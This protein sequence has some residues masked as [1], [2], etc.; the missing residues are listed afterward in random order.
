[1]WLIALS[2]FGFLS[3]AMVKRVSELR[4]VKA[5]NEE[6]IH[7]RGYSVHDLGMLSQAGITSGYMA[8][9]VFALYIH[10]EEVKAIYG[11]PSMLWFVCPLI[12]FWVSRVWLLTHRGLMHD[13]PVVFAVRDRMS[14]I[15]GAL[16]LIVV[17]MAR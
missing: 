9:L 13:D 7:G 15:I 3:L 16:A 12:F 2:M 8:V 5:S 10:G 11:N 17:F 14:Y 6:N 4:L 1:M